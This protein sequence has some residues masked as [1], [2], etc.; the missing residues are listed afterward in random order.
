MGR[1]DSIIYCVVLETLILSFPCS[2]TLISGRVFLYLCA[3]KRNVA[4]ILPNASRYIVLQQ[5]HVVFFVGI[6][7]EMVS[8]L[9]GKLLL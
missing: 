8:V 2:G 6:L 4:P 1:P 7:F 3:H 5:C 9:A